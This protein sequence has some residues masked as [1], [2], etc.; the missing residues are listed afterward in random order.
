MGVELVEGRDLFCSAGKVWMRTTSGPDARRRDLPPRR[1]RVPRPAAVPRRLDA[2]HPRAD[3]RRAARQRDDRERGRQRRRRRQARLHLP[4]R[5]HPVLPRRGADH[6]ERRHLAARGPGRARGGARPAR[7]ARGQAGRRLR[8]QGAGVGPDATQAGARRARGRASSRTRAAGSRSRSCSCRPSRP[9]SRT[10]CAR[11][12]PTCARSP[13]T[14]ATDVWVLPGG[15]TRVALPEG[16]LVVNIQP[17]RR[18]EGHL[19]GRS[20]APRTPSRCRS[21]ACRASSPTR[22]RPTAAVPIIHDGHPARP[23][24]HRT[25]RA[26]RPAA[27]AAAAV[28]RADRSRADGSRC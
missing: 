14:T 16:Q 23:L 4:A 27:A 21:A 18:V 7:R 10:G 19:G 15:L 2:R 5:P 26:Q 20:S 3:A 8:R 6:P 1:R 25:A 24:R 13:S 12:T 9:S 22:P 28:P 11:G 17:G